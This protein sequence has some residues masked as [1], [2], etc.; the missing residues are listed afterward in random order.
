MFDTVRKPG[1][2]KSIIAYVLFGAIILVFALFGITPDRYGSITGGGAAAIVNDTSISIA[3]FR[4]Q[5]DRM[6]RGSKLK[7]DQFPPEQ[8]EL[9]Q[10][11][12]RRRTL[13]QMIA[14]ELIYQTASQKGILAA[15][16]QI[17]DILLSIPE[18]QDN[19]RFKRDS[20]MAYLTQTRQS[21]DTFELQLRKSIVTQKMQEMFQTAILPANLEVEQLAELAAKQVTFRYLDI[22]SGHLNLEKS[23]SDADVDA[24]AKNKANEADIK[25]YYD[26]HA[27][28]YQIG[29][30][31]RASHILLTVDN[32]NL[33]TAVEEK[34]RDLRKKLTPE[35]FAS[36]AEKES[37][38]TI[39]AKRGGDLGTFDKGRMVPAFEQAAFAMKAGEISQPVKTDFGYHIIYVKERQEPRKITLDEARKGIAK[40][41][42]ARA[43]VPEAIAGIKKSVESG[44]IGEVDAAAKRFGVN[45]EKAENIS[46]GSPQIPGIADPQDLLA[47]VAQMYGKTGLVP[48]LVG[49]VSNQY[50][51][52][53][54][55]WKKS[56]KAPSR[57]EVRQNLAYQKSMDVFDEWIKSAEAKA[58]ITRNGQLLER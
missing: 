4:S 49:T 51:V 1:R 11:E 39:S 2:T 30:K 52:E 28:D 34:A 7:L 48:R 12:L 15:D 47:D 27:L 19:G 31:L 9:V 16:G 5:V 22:S 44:K 24:F 6:E 23:V 13:E 10:R 58:T 26:S 53:V 57:D 43:K 37:K 17:R 3:D 20:Y 21:P 32:K 40:K 45:W 18:F 36:F 29:E 33:A 50:I 38:D 25:A 14:G 56:D 42:I 8:R 54:M 41:L 35:N 55:G 46:L